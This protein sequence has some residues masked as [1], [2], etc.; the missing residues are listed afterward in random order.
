MDDIL[1]AF[2]SLRKHPGF[3]VVAVLTLAVGIGVSVS[4]FSMVS[5]LFLQPLPVKGAEQLVIVMQR[6]AVP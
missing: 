5:A 6:S 3:T 2:R 1:H 4:L